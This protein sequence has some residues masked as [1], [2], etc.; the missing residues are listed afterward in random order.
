MDSVILGKLEIKFPT[1]LQPAL[2]ECFQGSTLCP[3]AATIELEKI[4]NGRHKC[5][6]EKI[7][8]EDS[9]RLRKKIKTCSHNTSEHSKITRYNNW[10][11]VRVT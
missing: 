11:K 1:C 8:Y 4:Q 10:Q 6:Q 9:A 3:Y 5:F 2:R 7:L